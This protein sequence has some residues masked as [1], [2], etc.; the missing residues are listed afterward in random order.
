[1]RHPLIGRAVHL[2]YFDNRG[3]GTFLTGTY[4]PFRDVQVVAGRWRPQTF[5]TRQSL[6]QDR[7]SN[8]YEF[9]IGLGSW[10]DDYPFIYLVC[11]R[12]YLV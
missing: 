2:V 11:S 1:M 3:D 10:C 7:F 9:E 8:F 4:L 5:P 6:F 12:I